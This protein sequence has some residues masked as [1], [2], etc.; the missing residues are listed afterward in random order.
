MKVIIK[1]SCLLFVLLALFAASMPSYAA[2]TYSVLCP[3]DVRVASTEKY[4]RSDSSPLPPG[5]STST[6]SAEGGT[7]RGKSISSSSAGTQV[8]RCSYSRTALSNQV[9]INYFVPKGH[10]CKKNGVMAKKGFVCVKP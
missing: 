1:K 4:T 8:L 7:L 3:A 6:N 10:A 2:E 5:W 9:S